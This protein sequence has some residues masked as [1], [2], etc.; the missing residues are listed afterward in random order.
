MT[1]R[2]TVATMAARLTAPFGRGSDLILLGLAEG[3]SPDR[4][5]VSPYE[6]GLLEHRARFDHDPVTT[7][8]LD[9]IAAVPPL[10][11]L[12]AQWS[13]PAT[14]TTVTLADGLAPGDG[15]ALPLPSGAD[16]STR[17]VGLQETPPRP[18]PV[19]AV[20]RYRATALFGT[21][22]RLLWAMAREADRIRTIEPVLADQRTTAG[23][24]GAGLDLIGADLY[25]PRFPPMPYAVDDNTVALYHLDDPTTV[26]DAVDGFPGHTAH[27]GTAAAGATLGS[28][29]RYGG[30]LRL[31]AGGAVSIASSSDF[32]LAATDGFTIE[33]FVRPDQ[34]TTLGPVVS[35]TGATTTGWELS[36]GG[37][38]P[39]PPLAIRGVLRDGTNEVEVVCGASLPTSRFS[40]L[41]M[42]LDRDAGLLRLFVDG[43]GVAHADATALGAIGNADPVRLGSSTGGYAGWLDEIRISS[44]A[45]PDFSPV[46]GEADDHY[47]R[48]LALF[49]RWLLP[50]PQTVQDQLNALVPTLAGVASPFL[51]TDVDDPIVRGRHLVRVWPVSLLRGEHIDRDGRTDT[52]PELLWADDVD[53]FDPA[54]CGHHHN[55]SIVYDAPPPDPNRD[56]ALLPPDPSLLQPPVA[57]ALDSL[58][59]ALADDG[60]GNVLHVASGF[61][62]A[63]ADDRRSAR[64][65]ML[66]LAGATSER[67]AALAHRAGFDYVEHTHD[68]AVYGACAPGRQLLV[69]PAGATADLLAG[70][71]VTL[72]EGEAATFT[73]AQTSATYT[74]TAPDLTVE[75]DWFSVDGAV[76]RVDLAPPP[77]IPPAPPLQSEQVVTGVT[78]GQVLVSVDLVR[79]GHVQTV[80]VQAIVVPAPLA[81]GQTIAADGTRGS[82]PADLEPPE[83]IF[84]PSYLATLTDPLVTIT[85]GVSDRMQSATL[86]LLEA[87]VADLHAT[88]QD[89]LELT[90]GYVTDTATP[91]L[92]GRGRRLQL[93]HTSVG[94]D[95][96]A[97]RAHQAGFGYVGRADPDVVVATDLAD[98][99]WVTGPDTVEVGA[100]GILTV[101]PRPADVSATTRL[102][103]SSGQ[104][105]TADDSGV[106]LG[107]VPPPDPDSPQIQVR[108]ITPGISWVQA[109]LRQVDAAGPFCFT[110]DLVP[111]LAGARLPLDD[112]YL[113]MNALHTLCPIGVEIRTD[114]IRAAVV[115]LGLSGAAVDPSFTYPLFRLHR[116]AATIRKEPTDG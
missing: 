31:V 78:A 71:P 8:A 91:T 38:A 25:V 106:A 42:V 26:L 51:V 81:D 17:L 102:G 36:V 37:I 50:T 82:T 114:K 95:E 18:A 101:S 22:A 13:D 12:T 62:Q 73:F 9:A 98:L 64:A 105:L 107:A 35:R 6:S 55:P 52:A 44:I 33:C 27:V 83:P 14:T 79:N 19:P 99:A 58:V 20:T 2:A 4:I 41:A 115:E 45:R 57:A 66:R 7:Y 40:H 94:N 116:A 110:V 46:I 86:E 67:L 88:G 59:T 30:G 65:V 74:Q 109:T 100:T 87:L 16:A 49:R 92:V 72:T 1:A 111:A 28:V 32:D 61:D 77:A 103:W 69:G 10:T 104:L 80:G 39:D 15:V 5:V 29:G 47:R 23:A 112:Y 89:G 68:G 97:V 56:L 11:R 85:A 34:S 84:D 93:R 54:L 63:A 113:V 3:A 96:L 90:A 24:S 70:R 48:R 53:S 76:G 60:I 43:V 21:I 75:V 108:G